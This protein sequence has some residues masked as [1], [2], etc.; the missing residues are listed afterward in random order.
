MPD[1]PV[2][3]IP[4]NLAFFTFGPTLPAPPVNPYASLGV[5]MF[6]SGA[7][8]IA[9]TTASLPIRCQNENTG[10]RRAHPALKYLNRTAGPGVPAYLARQVWTLHS[11]VG[12]NGYMRIFRGPRREITG[13]GALDPAKVAPFREG[14]ETFYE[15]TGRNGT[16]ILDYT[17]VLHLRGLS[18]DGLVGMD[19][20]TV[21][22]P[23]FQL[24]QVITTFVTS[25]LRNGGHINKYLKF[26]PGTKREDVEQTKENW[27]GFT[28]ANNA[29]RTPA[30]I[31]CELVTV[32]DSAQ[33]TQIVE[34]RRI[35]IQDIAAILRIP[36]STLLYALEKT[37]AA[38]ADAEQQMAVQS[39]LRN[40]VEAIEAELDAKLLTEQERDAGWEFELDLGGL[41][42]AD[43]L[44]KSA[45]VTTLVNAGILTPNEGRGELGLG[46]LDGLDVPRV[47]VAVSQP[48]GTAGDTGGTGGTGG[49]G[50]DAPTS[51]QA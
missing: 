3:T 46:K 42:R 51:G 18:W 7:R 37:A 39:G 50:G 27:Q 11:V 24:A 40:W 16:F 36:A 8:Y 10:E 20:V 45:N 21:N 49:A 13:L 23:T 31:G 28:G 32:G 25:Y 6:W 17:D 44:T 41:L 48:M 43:P 35:L 9:E 14:A 15:I 1:A 33:H 34:L 22:A 47:P 26:A 29:G 2:S 12:G 30:L 19:P 5:P 38:T 4:L